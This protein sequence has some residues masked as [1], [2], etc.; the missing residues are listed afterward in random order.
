MMSH[1]RA[2]AQRASARCVTDLAVGSSDWLGRTTEIVI[3]NVTTSA[4][5]ST[6]QMTRC[7]TTAKDSREEK[8]RLV[9]KHVAL[10]FRQP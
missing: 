6:A 4:L 1:K 5:K 8:E 10:T 7:G 9:G 3:F 2:G